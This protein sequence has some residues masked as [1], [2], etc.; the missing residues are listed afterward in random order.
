VYDHLP[1]IDVF[2]RVDDDTV[3]GLMDYRNFPEPYFFV[4]VRENSSD[5]AG[6]PD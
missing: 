1:I 4:L 5:S 3:L 6:L 2:R